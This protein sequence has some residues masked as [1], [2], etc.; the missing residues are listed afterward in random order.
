VSEA[1]VF[2]R[3]VEFALCMRTRG[4][5]NYPDPV[6][7]GGSV[8]ETIRA[9]SGVDP[10]SPQFSGARSACKHLLPNNGVAAPS[11][12]QTITPAERAD[13]LKAAACMRSHGVTD[14]PDPTFQDDT[15]RFNSSSPI[16]T[17]SPQYESA[18][19]TCRKLI[20]AGATPPARPP[21][22]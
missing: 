16:D 22:P 18:L 12:A 5:P 13:Y 4:E 20:P 3:A 8:H 6:S 7:E 17:T 11:P 14:F 2:A 21:T 19:T 9:G 10:N 1:S 15:V